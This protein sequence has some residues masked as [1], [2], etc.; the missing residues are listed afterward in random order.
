[1]QTVLVELQNNYAL[2]FLLNLER[3]NVIRLLDLPKVER[4][5]KLSSQLRGSISRERAVELNKQLEITRHEWEQRN[6]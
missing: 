3:I 6:I 2:D 4:K 1:M 5:V